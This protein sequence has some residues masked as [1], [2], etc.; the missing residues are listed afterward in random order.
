MYEAVRHL[1]GIRV[2]ESVGATVG[3]KDVNIGEIGNRG[4]TRGMRTI[5]RV[6]LLSMCY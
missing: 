1:R 6:C 3:R 2:E 5:M 4:H